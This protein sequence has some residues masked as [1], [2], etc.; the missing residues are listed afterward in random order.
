ML[1]VRIIVI[2]KE[3]AIQTE[4]VF[5]F[6]FFI[7]FIFLFLFSHKGICN[8]GYTGVACEYTITTVSSAREIT[9]NLQ[10]GQWNYFYFNCTTSFVV[11]QLTETQSTGKL[12]LYVS[13]TG[14]PTLEDFLYSEANLNSS[15]HQIM[16]R[17]NSPSF[18]NY[19]VGIF[20]NSNINSGQSVP[21]TFVS[22]FTPF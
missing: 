17:H 3:H 10:N 14:Y 6:I 5:I 2:I 15:F 7:F 13:L 21:Y 12:A 1:F 8:Y 11:M 16:N 19:F 9:G 20:G 4:N 18:E 22:W